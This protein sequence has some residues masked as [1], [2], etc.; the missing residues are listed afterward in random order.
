MLAPLLFMVEALDPSNASESAHTIPDTY[1]E[2][3][4]IN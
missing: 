4:H 1:T 2:Y 3:V